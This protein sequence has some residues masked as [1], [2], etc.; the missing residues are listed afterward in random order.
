MMLLV[1]MSP[2]VPKER[3]LVLIAEP[4]IWCIH[5]GEQPE[6]RSWSRLLQPKGEQMQPS[7]GVV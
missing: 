6:R 1:A 2:A 7:T 5:P 4:C 3:D